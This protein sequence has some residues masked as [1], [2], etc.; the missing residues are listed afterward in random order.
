MSIW[1]SVFGIDEWSGRE[2]D[3]IKLMSLKAVNIKLS[4]LMSSIEINIKK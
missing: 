1:Q 2:I 3:L 4:Q